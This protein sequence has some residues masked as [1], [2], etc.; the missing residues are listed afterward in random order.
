MPLIPAFRRQS[1]ADLLVQGQSREQVPGQPSLGSE[2]IGK[3][4]V[5]NRIR[6]RACSNLR[7][8]Q[9]FAI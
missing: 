8:Q 1:H 3:Q 6:S 9:N 5:S 4:K 2:G 7:K